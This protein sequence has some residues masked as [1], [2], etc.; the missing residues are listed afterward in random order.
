ML[1]S[2]ENY[3]VDI[4]K[5][6]TTSQKNSENEVILPLH[7]LDTLKD[8]VNGAV[9]KILQAFGRDTIE[10]DFKRVEL[11]EYYDSYLNIISN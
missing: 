1:K 7:G 8:D 6:N 5:K 3:E 9:F 10:S 4:Q 2:I 11:R